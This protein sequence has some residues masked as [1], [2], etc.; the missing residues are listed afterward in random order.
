[1]KH[2]TI[3]GVLFLLLC[4]SA[5][6]AGAQEAASPFE[7]LAVLLQPGDKITVLDVNGKETKGQLGKLS[8]DALILMTSAGPRQLREADVI[9]I[10]Q[11]R[12]DSV[13]NGAILGAVAGTA[14]FLTMVALLGDSDGGDIIV[15]T[16]I[17]G[18]VLF[19]GLGAAAGAGID[20]MISSRQVIYQRP[21]SQKMVG[22]SPI[23]GH[24]RRGAA[25][26]VKF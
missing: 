2:L 21:A 17:A 9:T 12:D 4:T 22:V 24:G 20:A 14:Y 11:R 10:S 19:A 7:R 6:P 26:T 23:F 13:M 15:P 1:V 25:V 16:A 18:G 8:R 3:G 5:T